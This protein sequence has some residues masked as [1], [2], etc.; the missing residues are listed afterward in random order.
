LARYLDWLTGIVQLDPGQSYLGGVSIAV[1][2]RNRFPVTAMIMVF[3]FGFTMFFGTTFGVIAAVLQNRPPD[4]V[5]R[6]FSVFG[7]A[8]P[9]FYLLTLLMIIPAILWHYAPPFGYVPFWEEPF[10]A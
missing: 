7:Q 5:V 3:A 2:L 8:V 6:V 4:Y 1:E 9:D 10:R